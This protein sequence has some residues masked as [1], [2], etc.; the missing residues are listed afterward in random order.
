MTNIHSV[1]AACIEFFHSCRV[2]DS[3]A[4][5]P[6]LQSSNQT[7]YSS[8]FAVM[9]YHYTGELDKFS[10]AQ[11]T[12]WAEYI[13]SFQSPK[14]GLFD[15]EELHGGLGEHHN[16]EHRKLHLTCHVLPALTLLGSSPLHSIQYTENYLYNGA[17]E[18]WL[19]A[20][21]LAMAW[22]EGNNLFFAGQLL[23][24]EIETSNRGH[25]ALD[26]LFN[27]LEKTVDSNTALWGTD[28]GCSLHKAM[29]G[30]YHQLIL[31][32]Y[33]KRPVPHIE[34]LI[35]SVLACQHFDGGFSAWRGGGTC[36]D[37]DGIDILVNCYKLTNYRARDI[38]RSLRKS[39]KHILSDRVIVAGGFQDREGHE[40]IHNSMTVTRTPKGVANTFSTWFTLHA[41]MD[42]GSVL[43]KDN[44]FTSTIFRFNTSC[45]MGWGTIPENLRNYNKIEDHW[46]GIVFCGNRIIVKIYDVI[47][48]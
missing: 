6:F 17:F 48:R 36:Q 31:Y 27:W 46:D 12:E 34:K 29:Y 11:K 14:D 1:N 40:F 26:Q 24:H 5:R 47:K 22:V 10:P 2:D 3:Y 30:A 37:I 7:L 39:L 4:F 19:N 16:L 15:S 18:Q 32:F 38:R 44:F 8:V 35:D 20:R 41:L 28:H 42:I 25:E 43:H 13:Q 9:A 33:K 23:I 21:D 45:S